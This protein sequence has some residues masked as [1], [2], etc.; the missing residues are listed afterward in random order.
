MTEKTGKEWFRG[1]LDKYEDDPEFINAVEEIERGEIVDNK[2]K[3][4]HQYKKIT[5]FNGQ[6]IGQALLLQVFPVKLEELTGAFLDYDTDH[7][8][9]PLPK[10]GDYLM[11][12]FEED[13][14][15][16]SRSIF[17]TIRR[18]TPEKEAYYRDLVGQV[19]RV[20]VGK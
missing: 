19:F 20:E 5:R 17:T 10:K 3:F 7:G 6:T 12:I 8:L 1:Y 15:T 18:R 13:Y 9:Y 14:L 16:V 4:R 2:I 11:L